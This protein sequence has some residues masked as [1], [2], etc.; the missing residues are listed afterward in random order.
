[1]EVIV[2]FEIIVTKLVGKWKVSQNQSPENRAGIIQ[3]LNNSELRD[4]ALMA[5]AVESHGKV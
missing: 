3:G 4:G 5:A 2:G 1:M